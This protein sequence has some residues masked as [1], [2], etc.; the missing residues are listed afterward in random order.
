M[1]TQEKFPFVVRES[2]SQKNAIVIERD[3]GVCTEADFDA[4]S[5]V[6]RARSKEDDRPNLRGLYSDGLGKFVATDGHR[7]HIAEIPGMEEKVP[8]GIW[9]YVHETKKQISI[10]EAPEGTAPFPSYEKVADITDLHVKRG[11]LSHLLDDTGCLWRYWDLTKIRCNIDYLMDICRGVDNMTVYSVPADD[12]I[13]NAHGVFFISE[14]SDGNTKKAVL[15]PL[16][17]DY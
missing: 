3:S 9:L 16:K 7:M 6:L 11:Y 12:V 1:E 15:M 10:K 2:E 5:W 4:L 8:A 13:A 17:Q 14:Q